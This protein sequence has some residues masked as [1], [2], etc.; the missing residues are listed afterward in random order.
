MLRR[1]EIKGPG[2]GMD[3]RTIDPQNIR[4][5]KASNSNQAMLNG[6]LWKVKTGCSL[7]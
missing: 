4:E 1:R 7:A 6:L 3:K 2:L 5:G